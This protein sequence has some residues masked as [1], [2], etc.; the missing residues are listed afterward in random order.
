[1]NLVEIE[2]V[3]A[4]SVNLNSIQGGSTCLEVFL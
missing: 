2:L 1:M 4:C 3:Y